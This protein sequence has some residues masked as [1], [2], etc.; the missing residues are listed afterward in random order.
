MS[1][2]VLPDIVLRQ[3]PES[4]GSLKIE[5]QDVTLT[6]F[7]SLGQDS[8]V[9]PDVTGKSFQIAD[10]ELRTEGFLV[11]FTP[12]VSAA[13]GKDIV[14][15]TEPGQGELAPK[16]STV[17]LFYSTGPEFVVIPDLQGL[18]YNQALSLLEENSLLLGGETSYTGET[19]P[20]NDKYVI[21]QSP[22]AGGKYPPNTL[23][24]I[25]VGT[26]KNLYDFLNPTTIPEEAVMLEVRGL[27]FL[28]AMEELDPL[29]VAEYRMSKWNNATPLDPKNPDDRSKIY[30]IEQNPKPGVK[31]RPA[32]G[33]TL[34]YGSAADLEA[35]R[36]PTTTTTAP[37]TTTTTTSEETDPP[38]TTPAD[39]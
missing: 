15:R 21:K 24:L 9:V 33:V 30:I 20:D 37:P 23:V 5:P 38:T 31:F 25:T 2:T 35:Y 18:P 28:R 1:E 11:K 14:I 13:V 32:N 4:D 26:A 16:G 39:D 3:D 22:E 12:E 29:G 17:E 10:I 7:V 34:T 36:N 8:A 6:L 27:T 19:I